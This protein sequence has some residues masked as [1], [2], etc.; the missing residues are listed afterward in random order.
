MYLSIK[1]DFM[2]NVLLFLCLLLATVSTAQVEN[3]ED[4]DKFW[5][6][7]ILAIVQLNKE[8]IFSQT[9]F[10]LDIKIGEESWSQEK[11]SG[12]LDVIFSQDVRTT[13][14]SG[15]SSY[16][17]AYTMGDDEGQTYMVVCDVNYQE[18][19]VEVLMFKQFDGVWK[20]YGIDFQGE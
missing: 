13:L 18:Y 19:V 3:Q 8:K 2:K 5:G 11:L 15:S 16:I 7:N 20:L 12:L 17:D 6:D 4:A 10:P 1:L 14:R 9:N